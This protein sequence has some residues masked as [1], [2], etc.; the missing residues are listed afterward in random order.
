[1]GLRPG[2]FIKSTKQRRYG[3]MCT[4][5]LAALHNSRALNLTMLRQYRR[6]YVGFEDSGLRL[7]VWFKA[8]GLRLRGL[9]CGALKVN[10]Q[11]SGKRIT[12][13]IL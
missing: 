8:E 11:A 1:M 13:L 2:V 4:A 10:S 9:G 7:M 6:S 5:V 12:G 3:E